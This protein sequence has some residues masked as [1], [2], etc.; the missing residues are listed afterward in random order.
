MIDRKKIKDANI[1]FHFTMEAGKLL[2]D[3]DIRIAIQAMKDVLI[4]R[5]QERASKRYR[6]KVVAS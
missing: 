6:G 2:T 5:Q 1:R 4:G 3:H